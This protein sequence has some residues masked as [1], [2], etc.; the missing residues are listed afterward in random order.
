MML[1]PFVSIAARAQGGAGGGGGGR[2]DINGVVVDASGIAIVG[3][4]VSVGASTSSAI[5]DESGH[6]R[7]AH[8]PQGAAQ[9]QARRLGFSPFDTTLAVAPD[10][11]AA[12]RIVMTAVPASLPLVQVSEHRT[13]SDQ[14]L[15]GFYS[16]VG[17]RGGHYIT[18]ER[19]DRL[20]SYRLGDVLG[21][22]PGLRV[23]T[24]RGGGPRQVTLRGSGTGC[25]PL[26]FVDGFPATAGAFDVDMIDASSLEGIEIYPSL[27]TVPP[28][29]LGP[30]SLDRCGVIALWSRPAP[31]RRRVQQIRPGELAR[32][33]ESHE[34]LTA[35]EVDVAAR[36]V[37]EMPVPEYPDSLW[38]A[39][40]SGR[41]L[42]EFVVDTTG[43][44]VPETIGVVT[45]THVGFVGPARSVAAQVSFA[46]A[47]RQNHL[48]RQLVQLPFVFEA[49]KDSTRSN[50]SRTSVRNPS[51]SM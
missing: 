31:A 16:R 35:A 2:T 46:P 49:K 33:V 8:V 4:R 41:V 21:E 27:S 47:K 25:T 37:G 11:R 28:E 26:F 24:G 32:L 19:L 1:V 3:A 15:S 14:R 10:D 7:L 29:L 17:K 23:V 45:A 40:I 20:I 13:A 48:V 43:A 6:F 34:V 22:V 38:K 5:T 36:P 42:L 18:R 44:V 50:E 9:I 39:G 30:R 12:L 51:I